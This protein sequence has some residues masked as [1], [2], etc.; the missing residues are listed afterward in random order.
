MSGKS[1]LRLFDDH[2]PQ[3][4]VESGIFQ[5]VYP[6]TAL[7][8]TTN[9]I[10]FLVQGS[11]EDYIDL[12]DTLLSLRLKVVLSNNKPLEEGKHAPIPANYFMHTLF[13]DISIYLNDTQIEGGDPNYPYKAT[14]ESI[15]NFDADSKL[16]QLLP[17]GYST[18]EDERAKWIA[19]SKEF[20]LVG[21]LR[22]DFFNQPKYLLSGVNVRIRMT[23]SKPKFC[24][25]ETLAGGDV[26]VVEPSYKIVPTYAILYARRVKVSPSVERGHALGLE[27][28][29]AIYPYMK[30]KTVTYSIPAGNVSF[31]KENLFSSGLLP[32][33]IIVGMV[34]GEAYNGNLAHFPTTFEHF[35]VSQ[36]A[37]YRDGQMIPYKRAYNPKFKAKNKKIT[38]V[39]VRSIIQNMQLLNSTK[40]NGITMIDFVENGYCFFT[41]NLTP[42]FDMNQPQLARD[43]NLRLELRFDRALESAINVI[44]YATYDAQIQITKDRKIITNAYI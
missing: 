37:L 20:E 30:T 44:A 28:M 24:L 8:G 25:Q 23:L 2:P 5:D 13:S 34:K 18:E 26:E 3:I 41:F 14:I 43:S 42:D 15:F 1:E 4:A 39:Y 36:V 19:N 9:I 33:L 38:D 31:I 27:T 10:E 40:D 17:A 29:N 22:L 7:D 32:K 6:V 16:L 12:N 35:N 21:A 11:Q